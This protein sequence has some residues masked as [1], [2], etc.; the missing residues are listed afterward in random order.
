MIFV[1][2]HG[3]SEKHNVMPYDFVSC[4]KTLNV[5]SEVISVSFLLTKTN[6]YC[7]S[8]NKMINMEMKTWCWNKISTKI[9]KINQFE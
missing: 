6:K 5:L 3:N 9:I 4:Q 2:N 8:W 1:Y 7:A